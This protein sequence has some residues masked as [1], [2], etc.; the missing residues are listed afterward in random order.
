MDRKEPLPDYL[1]NVVT[2]LKLEAWRR[3][4]NDHPDQT[5]VA[6]IIRGIE[7]G[8]RIGFDPQLAKLKSSGTNMSSA[9]EQADVGGASSQSN[10]PSS[11]FGRG[12]GSLQPVR[13]DPEAE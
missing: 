9:T 1:C 4:L 11:G 5:F 8:F 3:V 10:H 7:K 12:H 13:S 6:Y 2:P